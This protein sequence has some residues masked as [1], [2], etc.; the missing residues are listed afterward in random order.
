MHRHAQDTGNGRVAL[1]AA[2]W[3]LRAYVARVN[4]NLLVECLLGIARRAVDQR[5]ATQ[6]K[7]CA[8]YSALCGL[9]RVKVKP[10]LRDTVQLKPESTRSALHLAPDP[11]DR[12]EHI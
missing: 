11:V 8:V 6:V 2:L 12:I 3:G 9:A 4:D 10:P 7:F 5:K 1:T